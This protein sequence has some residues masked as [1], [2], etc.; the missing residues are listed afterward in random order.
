MGQKRLFVFE[1][2]HILRRKSIAD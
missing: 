1:E 2:N